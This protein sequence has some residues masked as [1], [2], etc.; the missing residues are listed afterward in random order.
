VTEHRA[1]RLTEVLTDLLAVGVVGFGEVERDHSPV[2]P[3][4]HVLLGCRGPELERHPAFGI[5]RLPDDVEPQGVELMDQ[6]PFRHLDVGEL[7]KSLHVTVVGSHRGEAAAHAPLV[8]VVERH[9]PVARRRLQIRTA[10]IGRV[11]V[12]GEAVGT[13]RLGLIRA[14]HHVEVARRRLV[15]E[16]G[17]AA[18]ATG[19][20][21]E[22]DLMAHGT[23]ERPHT[24]TLPMN[25]RT[26]RTARAAV[27][28]D[29]GCRSIAVGV[30]IGA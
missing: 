24:P 4:H 23:P 21:E 22:Q 17:R 18:Q 14:H 26:P 19:V 2:V 28:D 12:A 6:S 15:A 27:T 30:A 16:L 9:Q 20:V 7:G 29:A 3:G 25:L 13:D 1:I 11:F 10:P 8:G 5:I